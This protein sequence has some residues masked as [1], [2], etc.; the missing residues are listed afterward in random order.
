M[1]VLHSHL[2]YVLCHGRTPH[3]TDWLS[4]AATECYIPLLDALYDLVEEGVS[5]RITVGIT[6]VLAEMLADPIFAYEFTSYIQDKTLAAQRDEESF[7][8]SGEDHLAD[9]AGFWKNRYER[10]LRSFRVR[11]KKSVLNAFKQLQDSGHIEI[12]TS[13]ATHGYSPLLS[14]DTSI[15]AQVKQGVQVYKRHF[16]TDPRGFWLPECAYRPRYSWSRPVHPDN[17]HSAPYLRKGVEEFLGENGLRY[18]IIEAHLLKG[19]SMETGSGV[20]ADRFPPLKKLWSQFQKQILPEERNRSVYQAYY[21]AGRGEEADP[22][23]VFARDPRTGFQVWSAASGYPGDEWY[24]EFHRKHV[25]GGHK[26]YR[27]SGA[28]ID[29]GAK[30]VYEPNRAQER[31]ESHAYHFIELVKDV[32]REES[33]RI[34][35][36]AV[37]CSPFDTELFGHWWFEGVDWLKAV[38][39]RAAN[40]PEV[41]LSTGT[42]SL[43]KHA[44][45]VPVALPEGSWG[46]GGFHWVWLNGDTEWTWKLVYAAEDRMQE[47]AS[48]DT[49]NPLLIRLIKQA[50]REM[51]L[52]QSSDWQFNITTSTSTD[53]AELRLNWHYRSFRRLA[54]LADKVIKGETLTPDEIDVLAYCEERDSLF[55]D[56]DLSW[57]AKLEHP[58]KMSSHPEKYQIDILP[59]RTVE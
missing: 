53:Y 6:P 52:L 44:A 1:L 45:S 7:R 9:L 29:L 40:D 32:L 20:Y 33:E 37:I 18:F 42:E 35:A 2:P 38:L 16:G 46:E 17:T 58:P 30:L 36:P 26:Y 11:Y 24:L 15:Q 55:E 4:E 59:P 5:P 23:A 13:A 43:E 47:L 28:G 14:R 34:G 41:N 57:F 56:I 25:P 54:D 12:I 3:G 21:I 51:L 48:I 19:G 22:V 31:V 49:D 10:V 8:A 50:A 39:R 27:V